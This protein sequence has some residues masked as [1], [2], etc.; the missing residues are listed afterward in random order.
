M[1]TFITKE[2]VHVDKFLLEVTYPCVADATVKKTV[3]ITTRFLPQLLRNWWRT[4]IENFHQDQDR[5]RMVRENA[6]IN[7]CL[8]DVWY[9][10]TQHAD[11]FSDLCPYWENICTSRY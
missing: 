2:I 4:S 7:E 11:C 8:A 6:A 5:N 1:L 10:V 9:L 3:V